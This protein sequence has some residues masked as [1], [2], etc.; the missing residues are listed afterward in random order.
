MSDSGAG[1]R[2]WLLL[3][4]C[5]TRCGVWGCGAGC[6]CCSGGIWTGG[7]VCDGNGAFP[8]TL[9][10]MW[11]GPSRTTFAF[12]SGVFPLTFG[13]RWRSIGSCGCY[14]WSHAWE[15]VWENPGSNAPSFS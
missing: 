9:R 11:D 3:Y 15:T 2:I 12:G 4:F 13:V 10:G 6:C 14:C 1:H 5:V 8:L 7:G